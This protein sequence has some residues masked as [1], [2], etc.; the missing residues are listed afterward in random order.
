[1][2]IGE[3]PHPTP[4]RGIL[5]GGFRRLYGL[6][7]MT[8]RTFADGRVFAD[9]TGKDGPLVVLMHGWGRSRG[10]LQVVGEGSAGP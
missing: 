2:S 9:V 1:M 7:P 4:I 3:Y 8:L 6:A 10:D 5:D